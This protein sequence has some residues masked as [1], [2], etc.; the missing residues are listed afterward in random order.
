MTIA[1][2]AERQSY[3]AQ[4][5]DQRVGIVHAVV[6]QHLGLLSHTFAIREQLSGRLLFF[7]AI[8]AFMKQSA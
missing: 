8:A 7:K 1:I 6:R 4:G 2:R 5:I 3:V